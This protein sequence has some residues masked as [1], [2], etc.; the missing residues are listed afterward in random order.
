MYIGLNYQSKMLKAMIFGV[1]AIVL[2]G[3][4]LA[5]PGVSRVLADRLESDSYIIQFGN[6]NVTSGEKSS[7]SFNVTDTVGQTGAG[8]F[9]AYG[10]SN[11][12]VGSGFQYIYQID[13]FAFSISDVL[14]ELGTLTSGVFNNDSNVLT[15]TSR[16]GGGYT[17]YAYEQHPLRLSSDDT[18]IIPD[19]TCDAGTCSEIT[20][21]PWVN[22]AIPGFGFNADGTT[23]PSDFINTTYFRQF[24]NLAAAETMQV[25]MSSPTI[26]T[27]DTATITYQAAVSGIQAAGEY[28]TGIIY[29]AVPGY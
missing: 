16:G 19:T 8:P 29:I 27:S 7:A 12:F 24:A 13:T 4:F 5:G 17:V 2:A 25:V 23:V 9:G 6:F 15:I 1:V 28:A 26:A 3:V 20:A 18:T 10:S 22:P 21:Q 11:Y 14:I